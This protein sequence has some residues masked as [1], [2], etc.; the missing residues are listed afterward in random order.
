MIMRMSNVTR[1]ALHMF[2]S[3]D[4]CVVPGGQILRSHQGVTE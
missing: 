1:D 2:D 3:C 4:L